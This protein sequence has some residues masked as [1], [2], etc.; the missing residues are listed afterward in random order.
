M[1]MHDHLTLAHAA[2]YTQE[3]QHECDLRCHEHHNKWTVPDTRFSNCLLI[4]EFTLMLL[5]QDLVSCS[6]DSICLDNG[7]HAFNVNRAVAFDTC[8]KEDTDATSSRI[9]AK[10]KRQ[11]ACVRP[12]LEATI[13]ALV[14]MLPESRYEVWH[15]CNPTIT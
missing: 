7:S 14:Y 13:W 15:I 1:Q 2:S 10:S 5:P 3:A 12:S 8:N 9:V 4:P 11:S 6:L